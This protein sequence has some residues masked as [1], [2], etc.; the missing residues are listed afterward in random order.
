MDTTYLD[1]HTATT[2][3]LEFGKTYYY[4]VSTTATSPNRRSRPSDVANAATGE[5]ERPGAPTALM[6]TEQGPSRIDLMWTA[7]TETGGGE[8]TGYQ[9]EYSDASTWRVLVADTGNTNEMYTDDGSIALLEEGDRRNYR[10][11]AINS[12]GAGMASGSVLSFPTPSDAQVATSAPTGLTAMAM[13]PMEVKLSWTTPTDTIGDEI[14][15]YQIEYSDLGNDEE[16][17]DFS[18]LV[19][20]TGNDETTYTDDGSEAELSAETTRQYR[21]SAINAEGISNASNV[22][23]ATT[24]KA[25]G[26]RKAESA[27]AGA[28]RATDNR[29]D[30]G[31]A[32]QHRRHRNRR[33]P[34]RTVR[35][36]EF[37]EC[38]GEGTPSRTRYLPTRTRRCPRPIPGGTTGC[39]RSTPPAGASLRTR[40]TRPLIRRLLLGPRT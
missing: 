23:I 28:N 38:P 16:W 35:E 22:A 32:H 20:T 17:G 14:T 4:R 26:S 40:P 11:S 8:I 5:V 1:M 27:D 12:A 39:R 24:A 7:P 13:G 2:N 31:R 34:D 6:L 30:L 33:L 21:V 3:E 19:D 36:R 15:G 9:I 10:V 25:N 29:P 18:D 37:V